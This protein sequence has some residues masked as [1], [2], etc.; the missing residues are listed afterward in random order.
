[1]ET[2]WITNYAPVLVMVLSF[3]L[4]F[5]GLKKMNIYENDWALAIFSFVISLVVISSKT[6]TN[7]IYNTIPFLTVL[8]VISFIIILALIFTAKDIETF[9]KPL[10]WIGF[11]LAILVVLGAVFHNFPTMNSILPSSSNEGLSNGLID[12]KELVY[13]TSFRENIVF[14]VSIVLVGFILLKKK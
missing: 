14:I 13:G 9:K 7:F 5:I 6:V 1:M 12:L 10:A 3:V 8:A 11:A 4:V 2:S